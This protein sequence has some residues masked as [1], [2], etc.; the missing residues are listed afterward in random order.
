MTDD[1]KPGDQVMTRTG[2]TTV[3]ANCTHKPGWRSGTCIHCNVEHPSTEE[4][5]PA[6]VR[7]LTGLDLSEVVR[8]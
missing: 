5:C 4:L 1:L 3:L 2:Q 6:R 7:L 8:S